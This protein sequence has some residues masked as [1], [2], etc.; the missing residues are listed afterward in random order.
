MLGTGGGFD[1]PVFNG[2]TRQ[3]G[4]IVEVEFAHQVGAVV[5]GRLDTDV[6]DLGNFLG[7]VAF[8]N[9]LKDFPF[10]GGEPL[11]GRGSTEGWVEHGMP[12]DFGHFGTEVSAAGG[13]NFETFL[14][15]GEG[16]CL[17]DEPVGAGLDEFTQEH[18]V[19]VAGKDKDMN[20]GQLPPEPTEDFGTVKAGE[21]DVE[22]DE[23]RLGLKALIK[24]FASVAT[25]GDDIPPVHGF[26]NLCNHVPDGGMIFNYGD[27]FHHVRRSL[28]VSNGHFSFAKAITNEPTSFNVC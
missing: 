12:E 16:S 20:I 19:L 7:A 3:A 14:E 10:P 8:R 1:D 24:G 23:I 17:S 27:L 6:E 9:E 21:H 2:K 11:Q 13:D 4:H 5:F 18:R 15:L 26:D 22:N 28:G 25:F